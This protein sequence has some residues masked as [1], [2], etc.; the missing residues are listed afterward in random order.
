MNYTM[1]INGLFLVTRVILCYPFM[2]PRRKGPGGIMQPIPETVS[3]C[4][5][6]IKSAQGKYSNNCA[7]TSLFVIINF[8]SLVSN[9]I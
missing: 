6:I 4:E 5:V 1:N 3:Y 8:Q 9:F 7:V 2:A